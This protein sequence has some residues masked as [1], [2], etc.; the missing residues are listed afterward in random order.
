MSELPLPPVMPIERGHP[1]PFGATPHPDGIN[2]AVFSRHARQVHLVL[3]REGRED[4][5]AEIPLDPVRNRTGDVW[6]VFIKG[7]SV[8]VQYGYRVDGVYAP[9]DGHRFNVQAVVIDPYARALSGGHAWGVHDSNGNSNGNGHARR[10]RRG[11][12]VADQFDWGDDAPPRTPLAETVI[13]ELHVR[14]YTRHASSGVRHPGTF[15]GLIDKIPQ[16]KSLGVTAVQLM[17][18]LEFDELDQTHRHPLTGEPLKNYWG[19]APLSFFAPK[20]AYAAR[21]GQQVRELKEMVKAFHAAGLEVILDVVF[22]HT[23]EGDERG[24][25]LSLRGLDNAIYYLLDKNGHY[26]NYSGCGNTLNCNHPVVR[27]LI[28]DGLAHLVSEYHLDGF[29]FDLAS[30]LGRGV[31]GKPLDEPPLLRHIAEHPLL[32]HVK[33]LAEPWDA[34]GLAQLGR[35]PSWG[36]W[37]ELNGAFRDDVRKF[38]RSEPHVTAALAKRISGSLDL[39]SGSAHHTHHSINFVTCHDGFTLNDLVSYNHKHNEANG[40]NNRDGSEY[41]FSY[42]CGHEGPSDDPPISALRQRQMRNF[43]TILL[44]SQGVPLLLQGDEFARTQRGNN[45]AY[46]QDNEISWLDWSFAEKNT[47]LTRFTRMMLALRKSYFALSGQEFVR[48]VAWHGTKLGD[49]DWTGQS[50]ALA[51]HLHGSP[52]MYVLCNAFWESLRFDLPARAWKR[53]VDTNIASPEDIVEEPH[54]VPLRPSDHYLVSARSVVV[55]IAS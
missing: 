32:S 50:R 45:N 8:E 5:I 24:P 16:L 3:F 48:R 49:P 31:D 22:N 30:I 4:A 36:R 53:V 23:A 37:M 19:Y 29:R 38:L 25:T 44:V 54:A 14:G 9:R 35:F 20:A 41:N 7:L 1:R 47:G 26:Y 13:Y 10:I 51:F 55:L 43:L 6:H 27:E 33:L 18:V 17:P 39:Y 2:F 40:E 12:I 42:N 46:C 15:L 11:R 21:P 28:L 34:G 52:E